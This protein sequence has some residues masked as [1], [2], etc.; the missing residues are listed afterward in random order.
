MN[1]YFKNGEFALRANNH[2]S[3]RTP[4][5]LLLCFITA[6]TAFLLAGSCSKSDPEQTALHYYNPLWSEDGTTV[7]L[8]MFQGT[9]FNDGMMNSS[10]LAMVTTDKTQQDINCA[11]VN[12][13]HK[14]YWFEPTSGAIAFV[15]N[16]IQFFSRTGA[17]LGTFVPS[18]PN[19]QPGALAFVRGIPSFIWA[20]TLNGRTV[21]SQTNY[22]ASTPWIVSS[23]RIIK[24]TVTTSQV[25]DIVLTS[26]STFGARFSDGHV[27]ELGFDGRIRTQYT[28]LPFVS[29][30]P[31][32]YR[33]IYYNAPATTRRLYTIQQNG[34]IVMELDAGTQRT[35]ID[36]N[37]VDFDINVPASFMVFET[38]SHDTW[39]ATPEGA[40][41][42]RLAPRVVMPRL[43]PDGK[44]MAGIGIEHGNQDTVTVMKYR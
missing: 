31:W 7:M 2:Y 43:S 17:G 25:Q 12:T 13:V 11:G 37:V 24:D 32:H 6:L 33:L 3:N 29:T 15:Q 30:N 16:G 1:K 36:G 5:Q 9:A 10:S 23:E 34:L 40:P 4:A 27:L 18:I 26:D 19:M 20:G 35:I 8:G 39:L 14:R 41:L 22:P 38:G 42:A 44:Y 28:F 21:I